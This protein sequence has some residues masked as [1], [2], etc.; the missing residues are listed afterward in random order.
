MLQ[1]RNHNRIFS[2]LGVDGE[3]K[4]HHQEIEHELVSFYQEILIEVSFQI[5][6]TINLVLHHI[7]WIV[8]KDHNFSLMRP[9]S[10]QE[11][12]MVFMHIPRN[13]ALGHDGF[14]FDFSKACWGFRGMNIHEVVEEFN[15]ISQYMFLSMQIFSPLYLKDEIHRNLVVLDLLH[16]TIIYKIFQR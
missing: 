14:T 8:S 5:Q 9:I 4:I 6:P 11:V 10:F 3:R 16:S 12:E 1:W 2:I 7:P 13:K 15:R